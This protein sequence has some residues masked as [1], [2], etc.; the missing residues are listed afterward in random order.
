MSHSGE[1]SGHPE[2][3]NGGPPRGGGRGG[4]GDSGLGPAGHTL[5]SVRLQTHCACLGRGDAGG[6]MGFLVLTVLP[7]TVGGR[8]S[9]GP[10]SWLPFCHPG[11]MWPQGNVVLSLSFPVRAW[12]PDKPN[13]SITRQLLRSTVGGL[14]PHLRREG[15]A[16]CVSANAPGPAAGERAGR[17]AAQAWR[18]DGRGTSTGLDRQRLWE[19]G[20]D[21]P[22]HRIRICI[23]PDPQGAPAQSHGKSASPEPRAGDTPRRLALGE[24]APPSLSLS[25]ETPGREGSP[26]GSIRAASPLIPPKLRMRDEKP[27]GEG[28]GGPPSAVRGASP[29][30]RRET[31]RPALLCHLGQG[32]SPPGASGR[33]DIPCEF[34]GH[35]EPSRRENASAAPERVQNNYQ[36]TC[37][38]YERCKC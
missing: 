23:S 19:K 27:G 14:G 8:A 5:A 11:A 38:S 22:T 12:V 20:P 37:V 33:E 30:G 7:L 9:T 36:P 13:H 10:G 3:G 4:G 18:R 16:T 24:M 26:S 1:E 6:E 32:M 17:P 15:P 31:L 25:P 2:P 34:H 21:P 35:P 29:L 28:R